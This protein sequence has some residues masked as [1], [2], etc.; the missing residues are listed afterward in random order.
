MPSGPTVHLPK[1]AI[2]SSTFVHHSHAAFTQLLQNLIV[3]DCLADHGFFLRYS[4]LALVA[5]VVSALRI[6]RGALPI[7]SISQ[8]TLS[9]DHNNEPP[10]EVSTNQPRLK[11]VHAATGA[12]HRAFGVPVVPVPTDIYYSV[13][14]SLHRNFTG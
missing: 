1:G 4:H 7:G 3:S 8:K 13:S 14:R 5:I 2:A 11:Q 6:P 10:G 9:V 12:K